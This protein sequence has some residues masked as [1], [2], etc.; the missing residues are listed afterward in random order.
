MRQER[1]AGKTLDATGG[2]WSGSA[3][4][5]RGGGGSVSGGQAEAGGGK[6]VVCR[7]VL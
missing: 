3:A 6:G 5:G 7:E 4:S 2:P 1:E